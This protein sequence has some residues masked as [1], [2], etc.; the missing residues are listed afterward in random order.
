LQLNDL[1]DYI[2]YSQEVKYN[3][4]QRN[5]DPNAVAFDQ[6]K[7]AVIDQMN[8]NDL[9]SFFMSEDRR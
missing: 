1:K 8:M 7:K 9:R 6:N 4:A 2:K 5:G 3:K